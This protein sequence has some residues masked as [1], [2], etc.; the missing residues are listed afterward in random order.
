MSTN[1]EIK[2]ADGAVH[3]CKLLDSELHDVMIIARVPVGNVE[4]GEFAIQYLKTFLD[5]DI[6]RWC[7]KNMRELEY[8]YVPGNTSLLDLELYGYVKPHKRT[9]FQLRFS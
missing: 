8:R 1:P 3:M 6:G 9:E 5:D 2:L 4:P 7:I